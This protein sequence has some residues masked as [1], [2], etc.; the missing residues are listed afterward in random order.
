MRFLPTALSLG[1]AAM[2]TTGAAFAQPAHA[3]RS[4][5]TRH[6]ARGAERPHVPNR[7]QPA[8]APVADACD[9]LACPHYLLIGVGF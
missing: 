3:D 4:G 6:V 1:L 9:T 8:P 5:G 7:N 2:M